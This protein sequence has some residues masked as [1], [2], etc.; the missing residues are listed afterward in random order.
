MIPVLFESDD[1]L[2]VNKPEG[3]ASIPEGTEGRDCPL[4]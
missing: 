2:A 1:L 3:L 4:C